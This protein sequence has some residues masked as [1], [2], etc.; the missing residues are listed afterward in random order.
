MAWHG[1]FGCQLAGLNGRNKN[2][3]NM[4]KYLLSIL[5]LSLIAMVAPSYANA[6]EAVEFIENDVQTVSVVVNGSSVRV[7]GAN[8]MTLY[9]YNITGLRV[10]AVAID[11]SDKQFD[12]DLPKGC[13]ILKVGKVVRKISIK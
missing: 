2:C 5:F 10:K 8:G 12:L 11:S 1:A 3:D 4:V 13:Y 6:S 9:V 7:G